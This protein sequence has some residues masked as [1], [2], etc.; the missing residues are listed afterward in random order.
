[1]P[2]QTLTNSS[3]DSTSDELLLLTKKKERRKR[4]EHNLDNNGDRFGIL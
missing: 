3:R 1:M 4:G 2:S